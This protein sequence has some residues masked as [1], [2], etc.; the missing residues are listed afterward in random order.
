MRSKKLTE[1]QSF[2]ARRRS[3]DLNQLENIIIRESTDTSD[4]KPKMN[5]AIAALTQ[6]KQK[7]SYLCPNKC[8]PCKY[9]C[10]ENEGHIHFNEH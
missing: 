1:G 8:E 6:V 7:D 10:W 2:R 9:Y 5:F 4:P 3:H